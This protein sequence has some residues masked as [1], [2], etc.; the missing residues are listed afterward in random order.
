MTEHGLANGI[1]RLNLFVVKGVEF[2]DLPAPGSLDF[3][4]C[5]GWKTASWR[6]GDMTYVLTGLKMQTVV[7]KFRKSGRWTITDKDGAAFPVG[8]LDRS[9]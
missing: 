2:E 8:D 9:G 6:Q 5:G 3:E 4:K 7:T 1:R